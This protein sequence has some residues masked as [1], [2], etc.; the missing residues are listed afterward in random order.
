MKIHSTILRAKDCTISELRLP[1]EASETENTI[2]CI[3]ES[4]QQRQFC[5][6]A[7]TAP[8]QQSQQ[9]RK[10]ESRTFQTLQ[11][12]PTMDL[13][14]GSCFMKYILRLRTHRS[15]V[16]YWVVWC[17]FLGDVPS[18]RNYG[19]ETVSEWKVEY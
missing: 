9:C 6:E 11:R 2:A 13:Q 3:E 19:L 12:Q 18:F 10:F 14:S 15:G 16:V 1:A 5:H 4:G 17:L 8:N 7:P